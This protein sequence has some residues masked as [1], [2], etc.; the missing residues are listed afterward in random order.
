[1]LGKPCTGATS[2]LIAVNVAVGH[3]TEVV[4][5]RFSHYKFAALL[6]NNLFFGRKC[7]LQPISKD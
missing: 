7:H 5:I 1:M 4:F 6:P 2:Q 3:T